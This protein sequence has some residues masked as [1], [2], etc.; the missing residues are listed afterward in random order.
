MRTIK[1]LLI[2]LQDNYVPYYEKGYYG[3]CNVANFMCCNKLITSKECQAI[4]EWIHQNRP[5]LFHKHYQYIN[6]DEYIGF[7][8]SKYSIKSRLRFLNY[9]IKKL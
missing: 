7:Y 1:E 5:K 2:L 3:L 6:P 4:I 9:H 8:W